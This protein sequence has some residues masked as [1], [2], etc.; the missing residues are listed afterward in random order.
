MRKL[1]ADALTGLIRQ[2]PDHA[3]QA[4]AV[5]ERV[6]SEDGASKI[7]ALVSA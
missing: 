2:A 1:T 7:A 3:A 6:R 5:G 4:A